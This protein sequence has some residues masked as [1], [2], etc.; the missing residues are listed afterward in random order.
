MVKTKCLSRKFLIG[1]ICIFFLILLAFLITDGY[2]NL[3]RDLKLHTA[4][5]KDMIDQRM[6]TLLSE[7]NIFPQHVGN[8]LLF[9]S[10]L[11]SLNKVINSDENEIDDNQLKELEGDFLEFL[12]GSATH[13]QLRYIDEG[14][15]E[16]IRTEFDES[17]YKIV[18]KDN[19]QNKKH[20]PY[21]TK[22]INLGEGEIYISPLD[23]NIENGKIENRGA[24]KNPEYIPTIRSATPVFNKKGVSKGIILFNIYANYFLEDIRRAQRDGENVFLVDEEGYYLAHPDRKKEFGFMF[25]KN[26][27]LYNDYPEVSK[28]VLLD[29]ERRRFESDNFIFSF[30]YLCP[31]TGDWNVGKNLKNVPGENFEDPYSWILVT[32]SEKDEINN[33]LSQLKKSYLYFLLFSGIT[34]LII[35][36]LIFILV[37]KGSDIKFLG[38]KK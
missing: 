24:E 26:D 3:N 5:T 4:D 38:E 36:I 6:T 15:N 20:R 25:R 29:V 13:Y 14:G 34:V 27:T 1:L 17:N 31:T 22:T 32:I 2:F 9:L 16:I 21:F 7:I 35:L 33:T 11:S 30:R 19:L 10:K 37:F 12:K 28:E 23:L 8:D 18:S